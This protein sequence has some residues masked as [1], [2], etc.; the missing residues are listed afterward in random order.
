MPEVPLLK[1]A[2]GTNFRASHFP[3]RDQNSNVRSVIGVIRS[4]GL[5]PNDPSDASIEGIDI[6]SN[7][8]RGPGL[9]DIW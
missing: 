5:L 6:T 3:K 9:R 8:G 1:F 7:V 4:T 2:D